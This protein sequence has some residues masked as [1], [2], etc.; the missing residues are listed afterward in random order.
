MYTQTFKKPN[1]SKVKFKAN[2]KKQFGKDVLTIQCRI[3]DVIKFLEVDKDVQREVNPSKV[4]ALKSYIGAAIAKDI[5][6]FSPLIFSSRECGEYNEKDKEFLLGSDEK[7]IILDGQHRIAAFKEIINR[8]RIEE[9]KHRVENFPVTI[10]IY[11]HLD[12]RQ[13]KQLFTDINSKSVA[14]SKN[15]KIARGGGDLYSRIAR[16]V[17]KSHPSISPDWFEIRASSTSTK[18]ITLSTL[19]SIARMINDGKINEKAGSVTI[20]EENFEDYKSKT[21]EFLTLY[22]KHIMKNEINRDTSLATNTAI[23]VSMAEYL[24]E[25][26]NEGLPMEYYFTSILSKEKWTQKNRALIKI[27]KRCKSSSKKITI[28]T[29]SRER[30]EVLK[31]IY[32][33]EKKI[34]G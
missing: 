27:G 3:M 26:R 9:I 6:Y 10:Q 24:Y 33:I 20:N 12:L 5:L 13:E 30:R 1:S 15:L 28:G 18:F 7:I 22:V 21:T 11:M 19:S 32:S 14:I 25:N 16:E 4:S 8:S 23:I 34:K 17:A 31:Y 29:S 2:L